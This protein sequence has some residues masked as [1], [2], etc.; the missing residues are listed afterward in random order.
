MSIFIA[1][2]DG[3]YRTCTDGDE[4]GVEVTHQDLRD[5]LAEVS[6]V[7]PDALPLDVLMCPRC[8]VQDPFTTRV[9]TDER[10]GDTV[11]TR[12][13]GMVPHACRRGALTRTT[14]VPRAVTS[15]T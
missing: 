5:A 4:S 15:C 1:R 7:T 13:S 11:P 12:C 3:F 14:T 6:D 9:K 8:T 10:R 2:W